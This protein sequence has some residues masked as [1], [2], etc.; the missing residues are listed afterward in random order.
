MR[1]HLATLARLADIMT[2]RRLRQLAW[3]IGRAVDGLPPMSD[4]TVT[5]CCVFAGV[6]AVASVRLWS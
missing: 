4:E 2:R 3:V 5:R 6:F 1:K